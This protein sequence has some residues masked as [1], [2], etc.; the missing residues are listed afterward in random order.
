MEWLA[1]KVV[2]NKEY[3]EEVAEVFNELGSGGAVIDDPDLVEEYA[4]SG[5]WDAWEFPE[6]PGG[7]NIALPDIFR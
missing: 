6:I 2:L 7:K 4:E 1:I 5:Q 3:L